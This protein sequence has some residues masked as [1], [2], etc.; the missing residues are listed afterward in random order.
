M[1]MEK[2]DFR[3]KLQKIEDIRKE[4]YA[5]MEKLGIFSKKRKSEISHE[6][7]KL[8]RDES[9]LKNEYKDVI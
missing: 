2:K 7:T 4:L 9:D 8:A 1:N 5:E 6:L 3:E